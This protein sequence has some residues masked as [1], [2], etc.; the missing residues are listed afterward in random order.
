M[1]EW[2]WISIS[3]SSFQAS[4]QDRQVQHPEDRQGLRKQE[5]VQEVLTFSRR[6]GFMFL[7]DQ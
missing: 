2:I 3:F 4:V 5:I 6:F 1:N 7:K